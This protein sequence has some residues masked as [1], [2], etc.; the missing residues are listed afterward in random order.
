MN[1]VN[2]LCNLFVNRSF[3]AITYASVTQTAH[4]RHTGTSVLSVLFG[5]S[6]PKKKLEGA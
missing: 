4:E 6:I 1:I 5:K 2:F 3:N